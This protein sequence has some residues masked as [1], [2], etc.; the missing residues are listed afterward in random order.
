M[1]QVQ[2]M[3]LE[4][5]KHFFEQLKYMLNALPKDK[6]KQILNDT[7]EAFFKTFSL[8]RNDFDIRMLQQR[9]SYC[10]NLEVTI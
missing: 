10:L 8:E 6:A 7:C 4:E 1:K 5:A 3:T 2:N 9:M